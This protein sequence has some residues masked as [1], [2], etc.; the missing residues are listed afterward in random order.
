MSVRLTSSKRERRVAL[1]FE[2]CSRQA[3]HGVALA[4]PTTERLHSY[5]H[6]DLARA[7]DGDVAARPGLR[8]NLLVMGALGAMV[9]LALFNLFLYSLTRTASHLYYFLQL[10]FQLPTELCG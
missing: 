6:Q 8:E 9:A 5:L 1:K 10:V 2:F 3:R 4:R 7:L